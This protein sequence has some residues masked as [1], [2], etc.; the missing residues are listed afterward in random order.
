MP[1]GQDGVER[2]EAFAGELQFF[3]QGSYNQTNGNL[4]EEIGAG[5]GGTTF[6]NTAGDTFGGD[7]DEQYANGADAEVWF[8]EASV[9]ARIKSEGLINGDFETGLG[10]WSEVDPASGSG[11]SYSGEANA[12][13]EGGSISQRIAVV[14]GED[15]S[16]SAMLQK[17]GSGATDS[18][19]VDIGGMIMNL[20]TPVE[21]DVYEATSIDFNVGNTDEITVSFS[22]EFLL[23][24]A[25][26]LDGPVPE[27]ILE[28]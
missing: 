1:I 11:I 22:G 4:P 16:L 7:I 15:Y 24:D 2:S 28:R 27:G 23:V 10:G 5:V 20:P 21:E 14:P 8:R 13:I 26:V 25:V 12:K 6:W 19:T 17:R 9:V 18:A 3:R